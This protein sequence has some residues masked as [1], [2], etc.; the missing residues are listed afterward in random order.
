MLCVSFVSPQS[1]PSFD[2][3]IGSVNLNLLALGKDTPLTQVS[4]RWGTCSTSNRYL[5]DV[6]A[7]HF[8]LM[9]L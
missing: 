2:I 3:L 7:F 9:Q 8:N 5:K 6:Q 4:F 1:N